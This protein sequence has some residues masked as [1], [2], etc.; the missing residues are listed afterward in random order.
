MNNQPPQ[1][2]AI[3]VTFV[4]GYTARALC[5]TILPARPHPGDDVYLGDLAYQVTGHDWMLTPDGQLR[6]HVCLLPQVNE[7]GERPFRYPEEARLAE[8]WG[9]P[10]AP[11]ETTL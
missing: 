4:N 11:P 2:A 7:K 9:A 8:T 5:A 3:P 6:I 10:P 1:P